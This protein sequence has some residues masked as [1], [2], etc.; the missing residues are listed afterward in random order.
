LGTRGED[1]RRILS[2]E[3]VAKIRR[4]DLERQKNLR[5][6]DKPIY[7]K[8]SGWETL[9]ITNYGGDDFYYMSLQ[10]GTPPQTM[11]VAIDT[12]SRSV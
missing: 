2:I 12:G 10:I 6:R 5:R 3:E 11:D 8:R 7:D 1:G 9:G 4:R